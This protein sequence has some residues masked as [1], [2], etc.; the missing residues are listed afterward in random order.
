MS[1]PKKDQFQT[2][3]LLLIHALIYAGIVLYAKG[4]LNLVDLFLAFGLI[5]ASAKDI[6]VF[7]I[8]D[9]AS[10]WLFVSGLGVAV[11]Q[12]VNIPYVLI[13]AALWFAIFYLVHTAFRRLRG[14]DGL[15][16]GD[17]KLI[18][19]ISAWCGPI[20]TVYVVLGASVTGLLILL[21]HLLRTNQ[22]FQERGVAFAP[23]LCLSAWV[24]WVF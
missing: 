11:W 9:L 18:A 7:E 8:P 21:V 19:G 10:L 24:M 5:A 2:G 23:F 15:G 22:E 4:A 20:G 1:L 3:L 13:G 12:G 6:E 16:F 17:V 14:Y